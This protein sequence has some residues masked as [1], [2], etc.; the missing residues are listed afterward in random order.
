MP[1]TLQGPAWPSIQLLRTMLAAAPER[2]TFRIG[3][4]P[5]PATEAL[6]RFAE[7]GLRVPVYTTDLREARRWDVPTIGR[8]QIHT[9]A[10]DIVRVGHPKFPRSE[11]WCQ[12]VPNVVAEW[13]MSV[14]DGKVIAR[15]L[16]TRT[17]P[18]NPRMTRRAGGD[19]IRNRLSGWTMVH[20]VEPPK[21]L[22]EVAR[23]AVAALGRLYG[24]VDMLVLRDAP[25]LRPEDVVVL[26]CNSLPGMDNYTATA[27]TTAIRRYVSG[28]RNV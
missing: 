14:F 19:F 5:I 10:N 9:R 22:R 6:R 26:E 7:A 24:T 28:Q 18:V 8:R 12:V 16:K 20:N 27:F 13:R 1:I 25:K 21:G 11:W 15:G 23:K 3:I 2:G 17:G 4:A